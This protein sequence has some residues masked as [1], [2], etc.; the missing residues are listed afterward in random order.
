MFN[1]AT[2]MEIVVSPSVYNTLSN[3]TTYLENNLAFVQS[4]ELHMTEWWMC[5]PRMSVCM[6][7]ARLYEYGDG[8]R[9]Y[10]AEG[11]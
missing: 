10:I 6:C 11:F 5:I 7:N 1:N 8:G 3:I 9:R 2:K 4:S